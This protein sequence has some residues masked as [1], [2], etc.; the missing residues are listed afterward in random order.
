L[1]SIKLSVEK[2]NGLFKVYTENKI[3]KVVVMLPI[4]IN[5]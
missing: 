3:F 5:S 1:T 4:K 2:Y